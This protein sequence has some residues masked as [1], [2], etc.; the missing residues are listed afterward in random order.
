MLKELSIRNFAIIDDLQIE[1]SDGLTV[2]SGETGAGKSIILNAVNLLLG[3][4]ASA[5]L[6]RT[7]AQKAELEALFQ[8][9]SNSKVAGIITANGYDPAEGL[10]I[11]RLISR[12]DNN[13]VYVNGRLAT[14][15]LLTTITENLASISG[16]HAHQGLLKEDQHLLILDQFGGLMPLR[17]QVYD[18]YHQILPLIDELKRLESVRQR[19]DEHQELLEFQRKEITAADLA[20]GEDEQLE[21]ERLRLKNAE[22]L[23][24]TVYGS[25]EELYG[26]AGSVMERLLE[27]KKNLD[28]AGRIDSQ[29]TSVAE[30]LA[31]A[32]YQIE[33]LT[34]ELR[35]H[36]NLILIDDQRLEAVEERLDT[37]NKLKRKYGGSLEAVFSRLETI[38][39]ELSQV[40]SI[41]TQIHEIEEKLGK[42]SETLT[43]RSLE[44]SKKRAKTANNLGLNVVAELSSLKMPQTEFQAVL[45]PIEADK[46]TNSYLTAN[47]Y[48]ITE[49]GIDRAT[50]MIAPNP[51]EELKPLV[52]IASGGELSRVVLA[53]KAI[54]AATDAVETIVFDEVD[55]GIGGGTAEV[56]GRKLSELA[57]HHQVICITHLPQIAKFGEHHL[58]ISKHVANGRT[59]TTIQPLEK[60]DR[61]REIARML[62]GEEITQTTL[63]HARELLDK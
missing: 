47:E 24:Q 41:D 14:I 10:L 36:L 8:I 11:R 55:A 52:S 26:A 16:Q 25:I 62:G 7:G 54:L 22:M 63:D 51:G 35:A 42:L 13:R 28:A 15:G 40:E 17:R 59:L 38:E 4:R 6:V 1:F 43:R 57:G 31:S 20:A 34:G 53:L 49:A 37:I 50:F 23:Y 60:E 61:Y 39:E 46:Q 29:L 44:L 30:S 18:A 5:D 2:L 48:M 56:V 21:Q 9:S 19:Q 58:S 12:S 33:D 32:S 45:H 27:V 3:T